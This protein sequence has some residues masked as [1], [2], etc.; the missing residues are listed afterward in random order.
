MRAEIALLGRVVFGVDEDRVV[1]AGCNTGFA[2][3][4]DG[5]V[6]I[7]NAVGPGVHGRGRT[8][9]GTGCVLTLIAPRDLKS[10]PGVGKGAHV[11]VFH[12]GAIDR[13]RDVIF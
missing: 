5:L 12:I 13:D 11:G 6:E 3:N 1:R 4:T 8:G 2:A 10:P 7:H 9:V